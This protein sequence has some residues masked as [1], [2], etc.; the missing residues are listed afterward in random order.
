MHS[1][2]YWILTQQN[3]HRLSGAD[4]AVADEILAGPGTFVLASGDAAA[5][6][7]G[8]VPTLLYKSYAAFEA[9]VRRGSLAAGFDS[10]LYDPESWAATPQGEREDP[11]RYLGRFAEFARSHG[12][13]P[14]LAPGR[15]LTLTPGGRCAKRQGET[16]GEAYVRCGIPAAAKGARVFVIQAAPQELDLPALRQLITASSRQA[17]QAN[18]SVILVATLSTAPGGAP[19]DTRALL[20]AARAMLP[21]VQGFMLNFTGATTATAVAFLRA[22]STARA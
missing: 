14:I 21:Y 10:V 6:P 19:A 18:P 15:D 3:L 22:L 16:V 7:R 9:D 8:A 1:R 5:L 17:R 11:I 20:R 2:L 4:P 12:Y 13:K